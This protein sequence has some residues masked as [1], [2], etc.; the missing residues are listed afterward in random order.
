[1]LG[2]CQAGLG[3]GLLKAQEV[4]RL[5]IGDHTVEVEHHGA[6]HAGTVRE[7]SKRHK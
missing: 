6:N 3:Q 4:R 5:V 1:M 7:L 2:H